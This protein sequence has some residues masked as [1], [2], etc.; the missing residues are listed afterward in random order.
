[1]GLPPSG[2]PVDFSV[3]EIYRLEDGKF[4]EGWAALD[5]M[6]LMQQIGAIP[7]PQQAPA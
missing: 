6:G 1:M 3:I 4:V 2:R 5:M 7:A